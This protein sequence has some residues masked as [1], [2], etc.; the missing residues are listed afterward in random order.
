MSV[1]RIRL[2]RGAAALALVFAAEAFAGDGLPRFISPDGPAQQ[3]RTVAV[4]TRRFVNRGDVVSARWRTTALGVYDCAVNGRASDDDFLKPGFTECGKC[5]HEY[6]SDVLPLIDSAK[7]RTNV[8]SATVSPGWWCDQFM[9]TKADLPWQLGRQVAFRGDLDLEYADGTRERIVTDESWLSGYAGPLLSAGIYEGEA[10]DARL[11]VEGLRPSVRN[12]EF[13]GELR[14]ASAKVALRRDLVLKPVGGFRREL[15]PGELLVLDFGQ[16]CSAVPS[17]TVEGAAG[18]QLEMRFSEMLNEPGGDLSRGND[19]PGGTPYLANLRTAYAGLKYTLRDGVQSYRPSFTYFGYRY[20]GVR[21]TAPVKFI[22]FESIPV[23]SVTPE[24]ERGRIETGNAQVNRLISNVR[25]GMLSNYLSIPTDC[26]QRDE[27]LGWTA[28]TQVFMESAACLADTYAFLMKYLDD[29]SDARRPN[30][31]YPEFAPNCRHRFDDRANAGWA[32]AGIIIPYRLWRRYGRTDPVE[33][34]WKAMLGYMDYL[35]A[36]DGHDKYENADWLAL[37]HSSNPK[38]LLQDEP[39]RRCIAAVYRIW[40]AGMMREMASALGDAASAGRFTGLERRLRERFAADYLQSDG[41]VKD[42]F[43]GQT[44]DLFALKLGLCADAAAEERTRRDLVANIHAH[45]DRLQTGFL[46]TPLLLPVLTDEAKE[47]EL[48]YTLLLQDRFPSWL[49]SVNQGATTVWERWNSYTKEKGFGPARMNSFNHYA[50][51]CV[52]EWLFAYA[53]GIRADP[54][55]PGFRRLLLAPVT[56][57]RLGFLKASYDSPVGRVTS[58]W[59]YD[60]NGAL[61][62]KFSIPAGANALVVPPDGAERKEYSA[63]S[64][65]VWYNTRK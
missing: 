57:R 18:T 2:P 39:Y 14:P 25:W 23:S 40:D 24:M 16:N 61:R 64:Y 56:D 15:R 6:V 60:G 13:A 63:G 9:R 5:R 58:E 8:L 37:E 20:A 22:S 19:G 32:D 27:R 47:P 7:G 31:T 12:T 55:V 54:S 29:L 62:W 46:G 26:P 65:E 50:Y 28:D 41:T 33:R 3:G 45:G 4:F 36:H 35:D 44:M 49:Y 42:E 21:A 52:M 10:Y 43:K 30:G 1:R 59:R 51:G 11:P 38:S 17:F 53:A 48:A 34:H